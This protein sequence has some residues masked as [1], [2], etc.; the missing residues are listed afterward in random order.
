FWNACS[1]TLIFTG[2]VLLLT[3]FIPI[4]QAICL[5]EVIRGRGGFSSLYLIPAIFP[6][7]VTVIIWK[8]IFH[9]SFGLANSLLN[10]FGLPSQVWY[11]DPRLVKLCIVIPGMVGGGFAVLLYLSAILSIPK[12]ITEAAAI[13]GCSGFKKLFYITLPN[14]KFLI[15]VQLIITVMWAMQLLDAPYQYSRGGPNQAATT[16]AYFSY[17]R[18]YERMSL[19]RSSAAAFMLLIVIAALTYIQMRLN[20]AEKL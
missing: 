11:S 1:N 18:F 3:F 14:M 20:K 2:L 13:D 7:S 16:V 12:E 8:W 19:G 17:V 6:L 15:M 9:P 10:K 4:V 5:S